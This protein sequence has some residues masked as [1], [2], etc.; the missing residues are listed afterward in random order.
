MD[1][2]GIGPLELLAIILVALIFLGPKDM[3]KAGKTLGR[4]LRNLVMSPTWAAVRQTAREVSTLPNRLIREAGVEELDQAVK[5]LRS[6]VS[7]SLPREEIN[8]MNPN[9]A[10]WT[11]PPSQSTG[12]NTPAVSEIASAAAEGQQPTGSEADETS[13]AQANLPT[14]RSL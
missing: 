3:V 9:F 4:T 2:F 14:I 13:E 12:P 8:L 10:E 6:D 7:G 5:D 1:I 11:T